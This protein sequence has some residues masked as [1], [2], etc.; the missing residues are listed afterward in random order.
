MPHRELAER[1][2]AAVPRSSP[3]LFNPWYDSAHDDTP[4]N[5]T[6][7]RIAR[8][9]EHLNCDPTMICVGEAAGWVGMKRAGIA[10]TSERLLMEGAIPRVTVPAGRLTT[11]K[12]PYSES[13]AT[14]V[15]K[16]LKSLSIDETTVLWNALPLHPYKSHKT[17]SNR[18]PSKEEL[19]HGAPA[20]RILVE[21]FPRAQIVAIGRNAETLLKDMGIPTAGQVRHPANGGANEFAE[22]LAKLARAKR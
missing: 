10:F 7:A 21:A 13:S 2:V 8:L 9:A 18:T 14:L 19:L 5:G 1:L 22:G 20:M 15:W 3:G 16:A 17:D 11:R 12:R 4:L 6:E